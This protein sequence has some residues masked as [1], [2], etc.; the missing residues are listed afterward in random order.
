METIQRIVDILEYGVFEFGLPF[1]EETVPLVVIVLLG[2]GVYFTIARWFT[3]E[4]TL[5]EG[6]GITPNVVVEI[7]E[8]E[9]EDLQL[10]EAI[11]LLEGQI[12]GGN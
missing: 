1:G 5:I 10:N 3:P 7:P 8:D 6:E 2:A 12:A 9:T 4:G 11:K